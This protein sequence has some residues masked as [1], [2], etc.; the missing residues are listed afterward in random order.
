ML[1]LNRL[2]SVDEIVKHNDLGASYRG[3][4]SCG[5]DDFTR[6]LNTKCG[7][8]SM[9]TTFNCRFVFRVNFRVVLKGTSTLTTN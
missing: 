6:F 2:P 8:V 7:L 1:K 3:V 4:F 5:S 9:V